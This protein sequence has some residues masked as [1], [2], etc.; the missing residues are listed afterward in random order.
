MHMKRLAVNVLHGYK[1]VS[2]V[3]HR[4][5]GIPPGLGCRFTPTCSEYTS[6]AINKYGILK[7]LRLAIIRVFRC[8]P[9]SRGG[10]EPLR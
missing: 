8:N 10:Y 2:D 5:L 9:W 7:G 6:E 1:V 3:L 4:V